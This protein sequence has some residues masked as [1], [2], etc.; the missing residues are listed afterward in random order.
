M[1][2]YDLKVDD[3]SP[4]SLTSTKYSGLRLGLRGSFPLDKKQDWSLGADLSF[5]FNPSIDEAPAASGTSP[6]S[7]INEFGIFVFRKIDLNIRMQAGLD[8]ELFKTNFSS[9][10]TT[11]SSSQKYTSLNFGLAY[12]F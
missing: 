9:G 12:M 2:N 10:S 1:S 6:D 5:I 11:T 4:R 8:F 7:S 3:T